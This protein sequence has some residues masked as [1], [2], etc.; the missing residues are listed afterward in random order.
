MGHKQWSDADALRVLDLMQGEGLSAAEVAERFGQSRNAICGLVFRI[1]R[2]LK[3]SEAAPGPKAIKPDNQDGALG[4]GWWK[5]GAARQRSAPVALALN[6]SPTC[7]GR[8]PTGI[9]LRRRA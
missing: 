2:E 5:A 6:P 4:R 1:E 7:W 8:K 9:G 3:E